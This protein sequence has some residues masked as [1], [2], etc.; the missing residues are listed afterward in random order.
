MY[1]LKITQ[2]P[3]AYDSTWFDPIILSTPYCRH[4]LRN[5]NIHIL[6][7]KQYKISHVHHFLFILTLSPFL[8]RHISLAYITIFITDRRAGYKNYL[9][10]IKTKYMKIMTENVVFPKCHMVKHTDSLRKLVVLYIAIIWME[11]A[12]RL[13]NHL[14][15]FLLK[16]FKIIFISRIIFPKRNL[17]SNTNT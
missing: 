11:I 12:N 6:M 1:I 8:T 4:G 9:N 15:Q 14:I 2:E 5:R 3:V 10:K 17:I 7:G 16:L 13:Y